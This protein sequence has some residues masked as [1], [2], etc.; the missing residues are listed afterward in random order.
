MLGVPGH[1]EELSHHPG[2]FTDELLHQLGAGHSDKGALCVVSDC[3]C[4]QS[5]ACNIYISFSLSALYLQTNPFTRTETFQ[6]PSTPGVLN[7]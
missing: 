5:L 7:F 1:D 6:Q 2:A 3:S 4:Q